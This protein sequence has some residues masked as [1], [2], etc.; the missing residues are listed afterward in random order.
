MPN[1]IFFK[2]CLFV[3]YAEQDFAINIAF[4]EGH[5]LQLGKK[6]PQ[7]NLI[8]LVKFKFGWMFVFGFFLISLF[9]AIGDF[10]Y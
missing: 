3:K 6:V 5:M 1:A 7:S 9:F 2:V 10:F 8:V 4:S